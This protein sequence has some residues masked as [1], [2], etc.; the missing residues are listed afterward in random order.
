MRISSSKRVLQF[1]KIQQKV[2]YSAKI[3]FTRAEGK[4]FKGTAKVHGLGLD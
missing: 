1:E 2:Y 3:N 4:K